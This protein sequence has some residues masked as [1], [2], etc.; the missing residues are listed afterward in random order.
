MRVGPQNRISKLLLFA[1][2]VIL[3]SLAGCPN[4]P[5][6]YDLQRWGTTTVLVPP[7][8]R[9]TNEN[10]GLLISKLK[11]A[12]RESSSGT[13]CDTEGP[14]VALHWHRKGLEIRVKAESYVAERTEASQSRGEVS[15]MYLDPLQDIGTFHGQLL[16]LESKGCFNSV[17]ARRIRRAVAERSPLPPSI[18][19]RYQLGSYDTTGFIELTPDFRLNVVTPIYDSDSQTL[20]HQIGYEIA[21]YNFAPVVGDG[22]V[23]ASL[24]SVAEFRPGQPETVKST[25]RNRVDFPR[26]PSYFHVTFKTEKTSGRHVT[27]AFLLSS[28]DELQLDAGTKQLQDAPVDTCEIVS[29]S[30]VKCIGFPPNF[31][32]S[33]ELRVRFNHKEA[34]VQLDGIVLDALGLKNLSADVP[35]SL[36]VTRLFQ[37][38][39]VP[40]VFDRTK[41][42]ILALTLMPGDEIT[43]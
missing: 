43:W 41:K 7:N 27:R 25:P 6:R 12:R 22:R 37:G 5:L 10:S 32:V 19:Y 1:L 35:K 17:E 38:R 15:G 42:D 2:M 18:A 21:Y 23:T 4:A 33:V 36:R 29:T 40:I 24:V 9:S 20:E 34:F 31:G 14:V 8:Q 39:P 16:Q 13:R 28:T 11:N 26:S 30:G 3:P